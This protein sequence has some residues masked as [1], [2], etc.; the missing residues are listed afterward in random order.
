VGREILY[1]DRWVAAR[2]SSR[3]GWVHDRYRTSALGRVKHEDFDDG[4]ARRALQN[5]DGNAA[6]DSWRSWQDQ[7]VGH[8]S[9]SLVKVKHEDPGHGVIAR[10]KHARFGSAARAS[11]KVGPNEG[12]AARASWL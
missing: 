2:S 10:A 3:T 6:R 7:L 4:L 8:R 9:L 5:V 12:N 11:W 1:P